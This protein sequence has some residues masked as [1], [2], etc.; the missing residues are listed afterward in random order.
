MAEGL[1]AG[2]IANISGHHCTQIILYI[3]SEEKSSRYSFAIYKSFEDV[4]RLVSR[5]YRICS[6]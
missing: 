2:G 1:N 4:D 3:F 5:L 6:R